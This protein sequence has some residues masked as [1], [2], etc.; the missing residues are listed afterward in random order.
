MFEVIHHSEHYS[1]PHSMLHSPP[2]NMEYPLCVYHL[3]PSHLV[4]FPVIKISLLG[5]YQLNIIIYMYHRF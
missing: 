5:L 2:R 1:K 4:A 3:C